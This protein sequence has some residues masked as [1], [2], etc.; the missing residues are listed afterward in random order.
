MRQQREEYFLDLLHREVVLAMGCTEPAA[1]A[2]A[3]AYA[4]EAL[5]RLPEK[6]EIRASSH[7]LKNGMN[8]GIPGTGMTGLPIAAALGCVSGDPSSSIRIASCFCSPDRPSST[9]SAA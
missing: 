4:A 1:V 8:V 7:I 5:G 6:V 3:C 9:I 2:L